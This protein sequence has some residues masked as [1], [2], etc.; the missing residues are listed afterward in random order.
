MPSKELKRSKEQELVDE[1]QD[2]RAEQADSAKDS[3]IGSTELRR[4]V[5]NPRSASPAALLSLQHTYGNRSVQRLLQGA[6]ASVQRFKWNPFKK[7]EA[8]TLNLN[9]L[10]RNKEFYRLFYVFCVAEYSTENIECWSD[11]EAF[12]ASPNMPRA[13]RIYTQYFADAKAERGVNIPNPVRK[14]LTAVMDEAQ[15]EGV[16]DRASAA[17]LFDTAENALLA[18]LSDTYS[19]FTSTPEYKQWRKANPDV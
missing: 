1:A 19:R 8:T 4:A 14:N 12:K 7:A 18:N 11:I 3:A 9:N 13:R 6:P 5:T 10:L 17:T 2:A 16:G 15:S